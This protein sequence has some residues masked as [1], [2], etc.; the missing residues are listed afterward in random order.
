MLS[1]AFQLVS[2]PV[3]LRFWGAE[4]YGV[5][6][7]VLAASTMFRTLDAGFI[8]FVGNR[9]NL[10]FHDDVGQLKRVLGSAVVG[11]AF[12]G[13]LQLMLTLSAIA[14]A[15]VGWLI[16][17]TEASAGEEVGWAIVVLISSWVVT[18]AYI[19]I[20]HRLLIP[21][22]MLYQA[23]WWSLGYQ[24]SMFVG[25][26]AAAALGL[27]ILETSVLIASVQ[28]VVYVSSGVYVRS[29]LPRFYPWWKDVD[30]R[31]AIR[32]L[33]DSTPFMLSGV[34]QQAGTSGMVMLI[35]SKLGPS[36]LPAFTTVRTMVNLWTTISSTVTAPLLADVIRFHATRGIDKLLMLADAHAWLAGSIINVGVVALY[37]FMVYAYAYWTH[38]VLVLD[39]MLLTT[40]LGAALLTNAYAFAAMYLHG[41]N[42]RQTAIW[43]AFLR[44]GIAL[45]IGAMAAGFGIAGFGA[46]ILVAELVCFLYVALGP[47]R[48]VI[49]RM[50]GK[51]K[52]MR[53]GWTAASLGCAALF[54]AVAPSASIASIVI[55]VVSL[56]GMVFASWMGWRRLDVQVRTRFAALTFGSIRAKT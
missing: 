52:F 32:D 36:A 42:N 46:G 31:T 6:L 10:L 39:A 34:L 12:L 2:V 28:T 27:R 19:G 3:C 40:L 16:G 11:I 51:A 26:V 50:G 5:W 55:Y 24:A 38:G 25:V 43:M 53:L 17:E 23:A 48:T 9:L 49:A 14:W 35:T 13:A 44:T 56:C 4:S 41:I 47:F 45:G 7:A 21:A 15:G 37:P 1:I 18:G 8:N 33:R 54:L 29:R 30:W 20:V 22:G